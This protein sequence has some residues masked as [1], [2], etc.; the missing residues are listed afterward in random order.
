MTPFAMTHPNITSRLEEIMNSNT[1]PP[2]VGQIETSMAG[3][4]A[5]LAIAMVFNYVV[6]VFLFRLNDVFRFTPL[7]SLNI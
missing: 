5:D 7:K 2:W 3:F 4:W 6:S 1:T